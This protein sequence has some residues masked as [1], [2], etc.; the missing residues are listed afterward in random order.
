MSFVVIE[1]MD[2]VGKSTQAVCLM[3]RLRGEGER[4]LLTKEPGGTEIGEQIR[5]L[6]LDKR[7]TRMCVETELFLYM[8]SRS[9]L[10]FEV[11]RPALRVGKVVISD[12]YVL[13]SLVYQGFAGGLGVEE[14]Q[15]VARLA[16]KGLQPDLMIVLDLPL[17]VALRRVSGGGDRMECKGEGFFRKV[18]E[19]YLSLADGS[20][21]RRVEVVDALGEVEEV[22]ER[23]YG[24]WCRHFRG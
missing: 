1:G 18:R 5:A 21:A 8:A 2:G 9:Q 11:I 16:T 7:H 20:L 24:V 12:R 4:V 14:V 17:Q 13:S 19:G 10:I 22:A 3:E 23:V 6:L 15:Q